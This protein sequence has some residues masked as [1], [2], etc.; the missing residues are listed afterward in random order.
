MGLSVSVGGAIVIFTISYMV[1]MFPSLLD[2]TTS[3]TNTSTQRTDLENSIT[4][5]DIRLTAVNGTSLSDI[6]RFGIQNVGSEKLWDYSRFNLIITYE[7][8]IATKTKY[9][10]QLAYEKSCSNSAGKWCV[11]SIKEDFQDPQILNM[12]ETLVVRAVLAHPVYTNGIITA[13]VSADNGVTA[14]R[15]GIAS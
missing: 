3:L 7:G 15:T 12:G 2:A 10:E 8:G 14:D 5:S 4:K 6:I 11:Y 9:T 13:L 1:M